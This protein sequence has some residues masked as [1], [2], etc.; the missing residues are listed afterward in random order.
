M[1]DTT[2]PLHKLPKELLL[3][4]LPFE[5]CILTQPLDISI[6]WL[7]FIDPR[8]C[9]RLLGRSGIG[10]ARCGSKHDL[11][12]KYGKLIYINFGNHIDPKYLRKYII[13]N[14]SAIERVIFDFPDLVR[15]LK[16]W[17]GD[18]DHHEY[19]WFPS[20]NIQSCSS[21]H[22]RDVIFTDCTGLASEPTF[23]INSLLH[24]SNKVEELLY[25]LKFEFISNLKHVEID[26]TVQNYVNLKNEI[27]ECTRECHKIRPTSLHLYLTLEN[28]STYPQKFPTEWVTSIFNLQLV[29]EFSLHYYN[30]STSIDY[31]SDWIEQM[32]HLKS[33][34]LGF[35]NLNFTQIPRQFTNG[36]ANIQVK[37]DKKY[38]NSMQHKFNR[39]NWQEKKFRDHV[40]AYGPSS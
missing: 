30:K 37:V 7:N 36:K 35:G 1:K 12:L 38:F 33:L 21:K 10:N 25:D 32:P 24:Q 19:L 17:T 4:V 23:R 40:I 13:F 9:F 6:P 8:R 14:A 11:E 27:R 26:M 18:V 2:P 20:V 29:E 5:D 16:V 15:C 31:L 3:Q 34:N 22:L 28:A 39:C